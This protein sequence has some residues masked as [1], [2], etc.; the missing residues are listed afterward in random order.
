MKTFDTDEDEFYTL[1]DMV[2]FQSFAD[3]ATLATH[4]AHDVAAMLRAGIAERGTASLVVSGGSTPKPF[5]EALRQAPIEWKHVVITLADERW[6]DA[7][8]EDSNEK[9]VREHL[10]PEGATFVS[11][12]NAAETPHEGAEAATKAVADNVPLPFDVV[13]LGM[14]DDGHTASFFPH[15]AELDAALKPLDDSTLCAAITPPEYAPHPRMTLTLP[16]ILDARRI[17]LHITGG[18]KQEVY[19]KACESGPVA[20]MPVRAVLRQEHTPVEVYWAA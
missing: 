9:L 17:I 18:S 19:A 15:A 10:L 3:K 1:G 5:F 13:I 20:D 6:V 11:L 12:K 16:A 7:D 14:G 8:H 4:L 2:H